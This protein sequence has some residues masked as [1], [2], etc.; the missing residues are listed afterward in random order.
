MSPRTR[1]HLAAAMLTSVW[2]SASLAQPTPD[3]LESDLAQARAV[4]D[5]DPY[6]L[7]AIIWLGRRLSYLGR[8][9]EAVAVYTEGLKKHDGN[10]ALLRHRGH[11][12]ISLR[13]F[14]DAIDDLSR[15]AQ[16]CGRPV[17]G[18]REGPRD[19]IEPDGM[20]NPLGVPRSTLRFNVWYHLALAYYLRG[21]D[22]DLDKARDAW[23]SCMVYARRND[24]MTVA[25][26]NWL[27]LT[28]LR[29]GHA[30]AARATLTPITGAMGLA[31]NEGYLDLC[32]LHKGERTEADEPFASALRSASK[33]APGD[34]R[35]ASNTLLYGVGV[36]R[37]IRGDKDGA[38][39]LFRTIVALSPPG[40]PG[41]A[42]FAR[43]A[44]E[45]ELIRGDA[46]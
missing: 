14:D 4:Y 17:V 44:A 24:D 29:L 10:I 27:A 12:Y 31:E 1:A 25:A 13:R 20:P 34:G 5:A 42:S 36:H 28:D 15:A 11:R 40:S 45:R 30:D 3:R 23:A 37:L 22:G 38:I 21:G 9:D 35:V 16:Q 18:F 39:D 32:L 33:A 41:Y 43:I 19:E 2:A 26:A 8:F 7:D 6:D 46:R